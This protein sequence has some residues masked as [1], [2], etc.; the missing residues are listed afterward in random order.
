M[1]SPFVRRQDLGRS[2]SST[3]Q[4]VVLKSYDTG[5]CD[6]NRVCRESDRFRRR[7]THS[8]PGPGDAARVGPEAVVSLQMPGR[9]VSSETVT[10]GLAI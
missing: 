6:V 8:R 1:L 10:F 7:K 9:L 3:L 2:D 5:L 4:N